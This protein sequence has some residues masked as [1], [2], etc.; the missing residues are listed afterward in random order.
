MRLEGT[1]LQSAG[2]AVRGGSPDLIGGSR[3]EI[4]RYSDV[5]QG[6]AGKFVEALGPAR[7]EAEDTEEEG[8]RFVLKRP[9]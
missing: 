6:A 5:L 4:D 3:P 1:V 7:P 8:D 2:C 9:G